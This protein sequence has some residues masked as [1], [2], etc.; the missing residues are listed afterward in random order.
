VAYNSQDTDE[1]PLRHDSTFMLIKKYL[2]YKMMG[3]N[4]FINHSFRA[5]KLFY[6]IMGVRLTNSVIENTAGSIFTGGVGLD[7]LLK[8]V[9]KLEK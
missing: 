5:M 6:K 2:I 7:D 4:F 9:D 3:S 8:D 1:N